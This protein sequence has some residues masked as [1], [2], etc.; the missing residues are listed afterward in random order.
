MNI[1]TLFPAKCILST[2]FV[3]VFFL[4]ARAVMPGEVR[5]NNEISDTTKITR[6]LV[7][8]S[9][10]KGSQSANILKLAHNFDGVTYGGGTLDKSPE[11]LTVNLDSLDCTT[12]VENVL[13]MTMTL[14]EGR[15][16]WRDF[17]YNLEKL[18]YRGGNINGYSSRLH[19]ISDWI[20]NNVYRGNLIEVTS[21]ICPNVDYQVKTLDFMSANRD[22]YPAL[23]EDAEF[24]KLKGVEIGYRSHKY[25][26]IKVQNI[27]NAELKD[28]DVI[29]ITTK[30]PGL[31]VSHMGIIEIGDDG[32]AHLIHASSKEGR[33]IS[34]PIP[35]VDYLR[36][37]KSA[38]G[39]RVIRLAYD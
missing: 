13:A 14:E 22:K 11:M 7:E 10:N 3:S 20:V 15:N 34:D 18:R 6:M 36:K 38:T 33:V 26:Y 23:S 24:E 29:A 16:S 17:I 9:Q 2:L 30:L 1:K 12:F 27:N 21:R 5:W 4:S 8:V 25:P 31:D 28:G 32:K 39:I 19:Y 37:N 35:L